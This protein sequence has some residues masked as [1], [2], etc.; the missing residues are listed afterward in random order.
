MVLVKCIIFCLD[1]DNGCVVKGVQ[2]VDICDVGD[3]VEIVCRYD[4]QGVDEIMF[5]DI[6]V[7][8]EDCDIMV[9]MVEKMV[10]QV[11]IF[12]IVGG[13]ICKL[14]DICIMFNVGVDKVSINMAAVFNLEFVG[15]VVDWFGL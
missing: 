2:F 1:V 11:F 15:E 13:G 4:E 12:F 3:F 9:Y 14:E 8:Y 5:L 6:I 7:S 10:S